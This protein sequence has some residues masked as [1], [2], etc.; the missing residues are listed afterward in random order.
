MAAKADLLT[1]VF[2]TLLGLAVFTDLRWRSLPNWLT[3]GGIVFALVW[4]MG[5]GGYEGVMASLKGLALGILLLLLPF[6]LGGMGAGDVKLLGMVGAFGGPL[7]AW[8][9][10]LAAALIGGA[11]ALLYLMAEGQ[12][13]STLRRMASG[14]M[15]NLAAA[16]QE[17][18]P[19]FFPYGL[20]I[21]L[22]STAAWFWGWW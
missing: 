21:A 17:D 8:R 11:A 9:A 22:G 16:G 7:L 3:G 13:R 5:A 14:L 4:H 20:A 18:F 1:L 19:V 2:L 10:F 15:V 6:L 12:L